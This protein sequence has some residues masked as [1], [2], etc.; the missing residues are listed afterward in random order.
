MGVTG[1]KVAAAGASLPSPAH[2]SLPSHHL[3]VVVPMY[4]EVDNAAALIDAVRTALAAYPQPWELIVVD[5]G[6]RDATAAALRRHAQA[7][8]ADRKSTRLNSSH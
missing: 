6:S 5:D 7:T 8:G 3:S 1:V 4:N 2:L